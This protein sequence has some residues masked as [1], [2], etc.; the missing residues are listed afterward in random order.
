MVVDQRHELTPG[1][2]IAPESPKHLAGHHCNTGFVNAAHCHAL[3]RGFHDHADTLRC[4]NVIYGVCNLSSQFFLDLQTFGIGF[5]HPCKFTDADNSIAGQISNMSTANDRQH[6]V[7][8]MR[9]KPNVTKDDHLVITFDFFE[10][11]LEI[12]DG[13]VAIAVKEFLVGARDAS[14]RASKA[15]PIRI[16]ADPLYEGSNSLFR[17]LARRSR[18]RGHAFIS[19]L[20]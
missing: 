19:A 11:F 20:V 4:E 8:A 10:G 15:F 5:H 12:P 17:L 16:V 1:S 13:I 6:V 9:L 3:V 2:G 18:S 14:R 7:L